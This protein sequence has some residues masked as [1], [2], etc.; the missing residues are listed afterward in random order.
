MKALITG[1]SSGIG[2]DIAKILAR[3]GVNLILVARRGDRLMKMKEEFSVD[4]TVIQTDLSIAENCFALYQRCR[5]EHVD[6]LV[7]NAGFGDFG[8]FDETDIH[9]DIRMME[10]NMKAVHI[11]MKLF[12]KDFKQRNSGYILNVASSAAFLPGPLMA[13]YYATKS[14]VLRLSMGVWKELKK[15]NSRVSISVLCPG[16]VKTEFDKVANVHFLMQGKNSEEVAME[17]IGAMWRRKLIIV[18]GMLMQ[19]SHMFT[20]CMPDRLLMSCSYHIQH[21][22]NSRKE[23]K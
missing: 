14:Y 18:P 2:K 19:I 9:T 12:L 22:K 16:P 10:T 15:Q 7:N 17:A 3:Q 5:N 20:K 1:A 4:V 11:L 6:I 23:T 21:R 8:Y 13:T